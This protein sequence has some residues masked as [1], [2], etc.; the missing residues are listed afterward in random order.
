[1]R[2]RPAGL[3]ATAAAKT[4]AAATDSTIILGS[5][6]EEPSLTARRHKIHRSVCT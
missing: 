4:I 6:E 3:A 5:K 2:G 1:M